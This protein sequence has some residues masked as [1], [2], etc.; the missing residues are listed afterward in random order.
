MINILIAGC[1]Q[2][3]SR[4]LQ[5]LSK[6]DSTYSILVYDPIQSSLNTAK[7]RYDSV[8][9]QKSPKC[10]FYNDLNKIPKNDIDVAIVATSANVRYELLISLISLFD[11]KNIILEKVLFQSQEQLNSAKFIINE[12][13]INTWVNCPRRQYSI[14]KNIKSKIKGKPILSMS[15][16]GN[17]WGLA[18][19][20]IHFIDLWNLFDNFK[21]YQIKWDNKFK[22]IESKR[23]GFKE[24]LGGFSAESSNSKLNIYCENEDQEDVVITIKLQGFHIEINEKVGNATFLNDENKVIDIIDFKTPYQSELTNEVVE[25]IIKNGSC[26]LTSFDVSY[27]L[28]QEFLG[29]MIDKMYPNSDSAKEKKL[30]PIT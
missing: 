11:I 3:G 13:N 29:S 18:C 4:H 23:C 24:I 17:G 28:H 26:D 10:L 21:S 22:T 20:A 7:E 9:I 5:A 8:S 16:N 15:V 19:N 2:L 25:N 12:K 1:G 6:L 30:V 27:M 14:Y